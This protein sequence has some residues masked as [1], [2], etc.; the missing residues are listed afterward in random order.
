MPPSTAQRDK[1]T[2]FEAEVRV[3][4]R[5]ERWLPATL[6]TAPTIH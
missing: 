6:P 4:A 3:G 1:T 5:I 2:T